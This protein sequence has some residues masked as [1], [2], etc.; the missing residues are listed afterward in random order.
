MIQGG[1]GSMVAEILCSSKL[2]TKL[3]IKGLEFLLVAEN[4]MI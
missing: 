4:L 3:F 2:D 1:I